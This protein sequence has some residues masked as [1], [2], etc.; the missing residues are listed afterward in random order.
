MNTE[1]TKGLSTDPY[2]GVRDFY[3]EDMFILN[4]IFG[5][6]RKTVEKFG[7]QEYS[8]SILEPTELYK[9]K[10]G[11]EIINE[12]TY[13]FKDRG[14][15]DVT[16]RPEMTPTVTRM[17]AARKR[18]L[19]FPLRWYSIPNLFRYEKPQRGR[20]REHY[21]LN[22]DLFGVVSNDAEVEII[23]LAH[24]IMRQFGAQEDN[25][26]IRVNNRKT[27]NYI[28]EEVFTLDP[29][30][31][32]KALKLIDKKDKMTPAEFKEK[33]T[34]FFKKRTQFF[35]DLLNAKTIEDMT[36]VAIAEGST[37][38]LGTKE[39]TDVMHRLKL[40]GVKNAVFDPTL[41]RG[42]DYYTGVV[43][44]VFDTSPDNPRALFGGGRFDDLL[45][46]F[47]SDKVPAFGFGMGDV[48]IRDYLETY[49]LLPEIRSKTDIMLCLL[50]DSVHIFADTF[51]QK[52]RREQLN[53]AIDMS[54]KKV[55][56][57]I[58]N[59]NKSKIPYIIVIGEDEIKNSQFKLKNL[60]SGKEIVLPSEKDIADIIL[61]T[62][63]Q[64]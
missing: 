22:V 44:E 18:E 6:M 58:E 23:A 41:A 15:R 26:I 21:Q 14:D 24:Q 16:L 56:Q 45:S 8:A 17:V 12:Q 13:S 55:G 28:L 37:E 39:V 42:F 29:H 2:K 50:D 61:K 38:I 64:Q 47:G 48:T 46:V 57:Q 19:V 36:E 62:P 33:A 32:Y 40:M 63:E 5:V 52:L 3:P 60:E 31:A 9:A 20:L 35:L 34:E 7:Y 11:E 43:F 25:F 4:Y 1:K 10:S 53:V 49:N 54:G 59:A 51:A 30:Q 27:I